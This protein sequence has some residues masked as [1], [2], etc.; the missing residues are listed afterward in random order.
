MVKKLINVF[1]CVMCGLFCAHLT[2]SCFTMYYNFKTQVEI[3]NTYLR[4]YQIENCKP[5]S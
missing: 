4:R 2:L 1:I 5:T 3:N